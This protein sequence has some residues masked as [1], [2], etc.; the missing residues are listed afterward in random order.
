MWPGPGPGTN[1]Q[2]K[3]ILYKIF[4]NNIYE[5]LEEIFSINPNTEM[6]INA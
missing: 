2:M 1:P 5:N 4:K 6:I 3:S